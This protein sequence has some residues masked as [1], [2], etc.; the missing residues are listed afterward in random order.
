M[1]NEVS[2]FIFF[3]GLF[4]FNWPLLK[5]FDL[6]LPVYLFIS[7]LIFITVIMIYGFFNR[8]DPGR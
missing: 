4:A 7:W 6:S 8:N 2:L 5:I 3:I 1:R